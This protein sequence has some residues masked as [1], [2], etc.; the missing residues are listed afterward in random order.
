MDL[1]P[2][3]VR[4]GVLEHARHGSID[5]TGA[6]VIESR[7]PSR[8]VYFSQGSPQLRKSEDRCNDSKGP[9]PVELEP[10]ARRG[11]IELDGNMVI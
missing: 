1:F 5:L 2:V 10:M 9:A 11:F 7:F 4:H 8:S 3:Y 6:V